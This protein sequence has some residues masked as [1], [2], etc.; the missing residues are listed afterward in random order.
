MPV[1]VG[2]PEAG[3]APVGYCWE[4]HMRLRLRV[5][6]SL[7]VVGMVALQGSARA[8]EAAPPPS[9]TLKRVERHVV[10]DGDQREYVAYLPK[11]GSS[12]PLPVIFGF[13]AGFGTAESFENSSRLHLTAR[14]TE[15]IT[16]YPQGYRR[17]WN[18]GACCG[19]AFKSQVNDIKF[20]QTILADIA[21][22]RTLDRRR[23]FAT[24]FSTGA[25]MSYRVACDLSQDFAAVAPV[26]APLNPGPAG[27]H[28]TRPVPILHIHGLRDTV[29]PFAGGVGAI[30]EAGTLPSIDKSISFWVEFNGCK[31]TD[32]ENLIA[33]A[34]CVEHA[35]CRANAAV[36]LCTIDKLGHNWPGNTYS[37]LLERTMG[38]SVPDIDATDAVIDFF[39]RHPMP[40]S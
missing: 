24:G 8:R 34:K 14:A 18:A 21:T 26:G 13:H 3:T 28:P 9:P 1:N 11:A 23:I 12:V 17:S 5:L 37:A 15:Y 29:A 33:G 39:F 27:C 19:Q 30:A 6:T 32:L 35:G 20:V 7:V 36:V 10:V 22:L 40:G 2:R 31:K 38:P 25:Q 4:A 16:I